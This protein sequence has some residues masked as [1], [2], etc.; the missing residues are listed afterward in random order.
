VAITNIAGQPVF[1]TRIEGEDSKIDLHSFAPGIYMLTVTYPHG[2]A[3]TKK[4]VVQNC[5]N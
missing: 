3:I 1:K 5:C 2:D 4:L